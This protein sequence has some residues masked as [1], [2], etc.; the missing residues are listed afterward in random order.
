MAIG[1]VRRRLKHGNPHGNKDLLH[2]FLE[3]RDKDGHGIPQQELEVE[4]F[5]PV[6]VTWPTLH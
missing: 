6:F 5:T 4:A 3:F 1:E 2:R